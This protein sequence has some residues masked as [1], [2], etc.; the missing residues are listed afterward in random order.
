MSKKPEP[1]PVLQKL[2]KLLANT[3]IVSRR[4][5]NLWLEA[6][7][8]SVNGKTAAPW[9]SVTGEEKICLDGKQLLVRN[10]LHPPA[11]ILLYHKPPGEF[12]SHAVRA[13]QASVFANLPPLKKGRWISVGRLDV[14]TSGLLLFTTD[15]DLANKLMHPSHGLDREY[16]V[17]VLGEVTK[18]MTGKLLDGVLL[19][20]RNARFSDLRYFG[21]QGANRWYHVVL[22]EGRKRE[23]R[24]LWESVGARVSKLK[25]VRFGPIVLPQSVREGRWVHFSDIEA[26]ALYRLTKLSIPKVL[27]SAHSQ[28]SSSLK[29]TKVLIPYPGLN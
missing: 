16:A 7:R 9:L 24:R 3:G 18:E 17:R 20:G 2:H 15:G 19:D 21:G 28:T 5:A 4:K 10:M 26:A 12:C 11:K 13:G 23:V 14:N 1:A 27:R 6:G 22:M 8:V 29:D 25:R